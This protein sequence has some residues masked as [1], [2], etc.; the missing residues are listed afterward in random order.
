[1]LFVRAPEAALHQLSAVVITRNE[2]RDVG[3]TLD[4]LAFADEV[5]VVDSL[6]ADRTVEV[7]AA[8]GARVVSH[9]FRGFGKQKRFA[10]GLASHDWVLC[11]DA[12]EVVTPELG[13]AIREL[14]SGDVPPPFAAYRLAFRTV[15]MGR[16]LL[17]TTRETHIRLFDRRR[18]GW[19]DAPVHETVRV[20]GEIGTLPGYVLHE[21]AR[22]VW[23]AIEKL[24][25]YTTL[26]AEG[27]RGRPVRSVP[28]LLVSG[29]YHFF[30]HYVIRRH[31]LS[32]VAGLAWSLLFSV[33]SVMKHVKAH[34][35]TAAPGSAAEREVPD[36]APAPRARVS[37]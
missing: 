9:P 14:L 24:N 25:A 6:S 33:G 3:R 4:A 10:V 1:M 34:E 19:D 28:S 31:F 5:L 23:E 37:G 29:A 13:R 11:I 32:G 27:R 18:A 2:E 20:N 21:S 16:T 17:H 12:D 22:S 26:A 35:L 15:F 8:R 7:C 30:R 36:A